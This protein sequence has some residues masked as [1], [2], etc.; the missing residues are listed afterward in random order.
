MADTAISPATAPLTIAAYT[1]LIVQSVAGQNVDDLT[2][3]LK[4]LFPNQAVPLDTAGASRMANEW[5][6]FFSTALQAQ[7]GR[8]AAASTKDLIA[9]INFAQHGMAQLQ[10]IVESSRGRDAN[11]AAVIAALTLQVQSI[12][13]LV[14]AP[15]ANIPPI[16]TVPPPY[17]FDS[18]GGE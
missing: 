7:Q 10:G 16:Q 5:Y 2:A 1:P 12:T 4:T 9:A 14:G 15:P 13:S 8:V 3:S 6:R 17:I 11:N 18:P